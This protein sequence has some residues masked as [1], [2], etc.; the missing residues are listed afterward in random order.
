MVACLQLFVVAKGTPMRIEETDQILKET[1]YARHYHELR[2]RDR[3]GLWQ[4]AWRT[5]TGIFKRS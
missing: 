3:G 5:V 2:E 1:R 4:R